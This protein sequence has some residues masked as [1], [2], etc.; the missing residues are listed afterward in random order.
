MC[1]AAF[2]IEKITF[3]NFYT[4]SV[5]VRVLRR[6]PGQEAAARWGTALKE[7]RLMDDPHTEGG[8]QDHCCVH[9]TQV[10]AASLAPPTQALLGRQRGA[11]WVA[12]AGAPGSGVVREADPQAAVLRLDGL[13]PGG[14]Q[15]SPPGQRCR[16][17]ELS[18][19]V[20]AGGGA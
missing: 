5:M 15:D 3:K 2:Q 17:C 13:H 18:S 11:G 6:G 20:A 4:A 16:P 1:F 14:H 8:S 12:D 9:R 19:E 7:L 10:S